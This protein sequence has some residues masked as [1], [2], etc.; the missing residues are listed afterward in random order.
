M[1]LLIGM[2]EFGENWC[3][4]CSTV[5]CSSRTRRGGQ[6]RLPAARLR[7]FTLPHT[8]L[9]VRQFLAN[10]SR[11][12]LAVR[13]RIFTRRP[14]CTATMLQLLSL[15]LICSYYN[16]YYHYYY[17]PALTSTTT[18]TTTTTTTML[19]LLLLLLLLLV[20]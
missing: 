15:L 16:Y 2:N 12:T 9:G 19:L 11:S 17:A 13:P 20:H 14:T 1:L 4:Q 18:T 10:K 3:T 7:I 8:L 5:G 6:L